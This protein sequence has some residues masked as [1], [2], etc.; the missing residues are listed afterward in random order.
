MSETALPLS[1]RAALGGATAALATTAAGCQW[2]PPASVDAPA[3]KRDADA[4]TVDQLRTA[5]A[6]QARL[7]ADVSTTHV[8]L[9]TSLAPLATLH[10]AQLRV[11]S[12]AETTGAAVVVPARPDPALAAVR[13]GE[14]ALQRSL[15]SAAQ[16]A[17]S[18]PLAR[19]LA[20]MAA[21][22]AMHLSAVP[23]PRGG[24]A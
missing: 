9:A 13:R 24:A 7:V 21:G 17:A 23:A 16:A 8:G 2:G 11:L 6:A 22:V 14:V 1:R 3:A 10:A 19:T 4:A 12:D 18:G 20:S 5:I 15:T